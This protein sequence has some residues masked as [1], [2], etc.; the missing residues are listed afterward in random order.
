[1]DG[2]TDTKSQDRTLKVEQ[3]PDII[4]SSEV[5]SFNTHAPCG[6]TYIYIEVMFN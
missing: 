2:V 4:L 3:D 5:K 6:D 1:M